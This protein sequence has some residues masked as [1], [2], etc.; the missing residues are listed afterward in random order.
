MTTFEEVVGKLNIDEMRILLN[1]KKRMIIKLKKQ[2]SLLIDRIRR[3]K[4]SP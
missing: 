3:K 4:D 1:K 2:V